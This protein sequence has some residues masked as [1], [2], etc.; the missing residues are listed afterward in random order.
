MFPVIL[1]ALNRDYNTGERQSLLRTASI[2]GNIPSSA[3]LGFIG[4]GLC[5]INPLSPD[6]S[7]AC[8]AEET[9]PGQKL[10]GGILIF[11]KA[12]R[13]AAQP[14]KPPKP[15]TLSPKPLDPTTPKPETPNPETLNA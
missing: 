2:S 5:L 13:Q 7:R 6:R 11:D 3:G 4:F 14:L 9:L 8:G 1:T 12:G 15:Q 10:L